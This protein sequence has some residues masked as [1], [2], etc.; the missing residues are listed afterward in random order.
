MTILGRNPAL[1]FGLVQAILSV[2]VGVCGVQ[3]TLL[4]IGLIEGLVS[5]VIAVVANANT[6]GAVPTF[7]LKTK[8]LASSSRDLR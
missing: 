5:A 6:P 2:L 7:S 8:P 1:I 4:Q 3:L